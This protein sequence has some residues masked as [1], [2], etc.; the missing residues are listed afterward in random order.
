MNYT[1]AKQIADYLALNLAEYC[2]PG[3]CRVA[4]SVRRK[5]ADC[6]DLE[7]VVIPT[8][9]APRPVFGQKKVYVTFIDQALD[10]MEGEGVFSFRKLDGPSKRNSKSTWPALG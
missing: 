4:G 5:K 1:Y 9:G 6:G 2:L 10:R 3:Y 7:L 8:P